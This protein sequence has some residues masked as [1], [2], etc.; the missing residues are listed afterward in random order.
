MHIE[1]NEMLRV[2]KNLEKETHWPKKTL[3]LSVQK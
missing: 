3:Y 1:P 2:T